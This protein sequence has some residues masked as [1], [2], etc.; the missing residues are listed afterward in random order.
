MNEVCFILR[1]SSAVDRFVQKQGCTSSIISIFT[2]LLL[3]LFSTGWRLSSSNELLLDGCAFKIQQ[4]QQP[5]FSIAKPLKSF[6]S[7]MQMWSYNSL[8]VFNIMQIYVKR[9]SYILVLLSRLWKIFSSKKKE[10]PTKVW[11]LIRPFESASLIKAKVAPGLMTEHKVSPKTRAKLQ[12]S[13]STKFSSCCVAFLFNVVISK[14]NKR[15]QKIFYVKCFL[16][17]KPNGGA[18]EQK[19]L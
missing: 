14:K 3:E 13:S 17:E 12:F 10:I 6:S 7:K 8:S 18:I 15:R 16:S 11:I 4:Q 2:F 19:P 1:V 5:F 9:L